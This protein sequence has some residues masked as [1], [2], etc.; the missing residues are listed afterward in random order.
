MRSLI[1]VL[2]TLA[3]CGG[4][5]AKTTIS[6]QQDYDTTVSQVID[7][8][9]EVYKTDG[10][11][12]ELVTGDLKSIAKSQKLDAAKEWASSHPEAKAAAKEKIAA[13]KADLDSASAPAIRQCGAE[14]ENLMAKIMSTTPTQ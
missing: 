12:C 8:V 3:A 4:T 10:M 1:F 9:I 13:R 14:V 11:N 5:Q 7:E 2:G 6:T